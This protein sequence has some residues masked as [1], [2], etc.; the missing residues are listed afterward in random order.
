MNN[1]KVNRLCNMMAIASMAMLPVSMA[2]YGSD[3]AIYKGSTKGKTSLMLMLDTSG[4]MG[5]SSLVLPKDNRFG[6]AGDVS[7][8]LCGRVGV[9]ETGDSVQINQWAYNAI[10]RRAGSSTNGKAAFK[11]SVVV[12]G[13][14]IDYYLR[15]CGDATIDATGRLIETETGKFDR[16]SRLKDALIQLLVGTKVSDT[17]YMG[18]GNFSS[19]TPLTIGNTTNKLVDGHSGRILVPNAALT[20]AHREKLI[21]QLVSIESVDTTTN[22][23]GIAN[24]SLKL[25]SEAYPNIFRASSGTPTAHAYAEAAAYM[26]GTTTGQDSSPVTNTSILYD[27]YSVMQKSDDATK[28]VYYICVAPGNERPTALGATVIAC[29][30]A[31]NKTDA[32]WYDSAN[33]KM[34]STVKIFKPVI[35]GGG[36][37]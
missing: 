4:S 29:D 34:G 13:E 23:D 2:S 33:M 30:N 11:K 28:Q 1:F 9:T 6:S 14:T 22:Q 18:L 12:N 19:R 5:I 25:S 7:A 20:A 31:W 36:K 37:P 3:L 17:V 32:E 16:L 24:N 10:D 21:R 26:M 27:G 15:G 35:G 8:S